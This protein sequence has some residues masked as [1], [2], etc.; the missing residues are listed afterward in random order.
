MALAWT[1][2]AHAVDYIL[3]LEPPLAEAAVYVDGE[4]AGMT[5]ENG[6]IVLS[7]DHPGLHEVRVQTDGLDLS[8]EYVFDA[9][10]NDLPPF[11][12]VRTEPA[13]IT[14]P[15][16]RAV[17]Q[18]AVA[19][20][21]TRRDAEPDG[22]LD[23]LLMILVAVLVASV[24]VLTTVLALQ[25][26]R[27][28]TPVPEQSVPLFDRYRI[29][30]TLGAGGVGMIYRAVD[31][32]EKTTV[33]L[34]VLDARWL[35]DPDMV[36][37][38]LSEGE[39]LRA[40]AER[41]PNGLIVRCF[42]HGREHGSIVGRPF[43]ALELLEGETLQVRLKREPV[44]QE[45]TAAGISY[46]IATA[47]AAVHGAGVVHRDLTPDNIFLEQG[48]VTIAGHLFTGVPRVVLIDFG[49]ARLDIATKVTMDGSIAGKPQCRGL[50]VDAR[51][52]LYSL[53]IVMFLM[54]AGRT[55]FE[56]RDPFEVMRAQQTDVPPALPADVSPRYVSLTHRL[57]AKE[58]DGRPQSANLVAS[59]L[60]SLFV[61]AGQ[62]LVSANLV[63]F[64]ERRLLP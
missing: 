9:D 13:P 40:V 2:A 10:L 34:K 33:A 5:D 57:L 11:Q 21:S 44:L 18:G 38:F 7:N 4:Y 52:D 63:P 37:K 30:S 59:E 22:A 25:R 60:Q 49:I 15:A 48:D 3:R 29:V 45:L 17:S 20:Q 1:E 50:V 56:G 6:K 42:R 19:D 41:D 35:T 8:A 51:S 47:L 23:P 31:V 43:I 24:I 54:V 14:R 36:R 53:G 32:V 46:Q 58:A 55:P 39:V 26:R 16:A 28:F 27:R 61:G 64:P 62:L 12:I